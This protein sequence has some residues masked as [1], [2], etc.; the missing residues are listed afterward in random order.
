MKCP[1]SE[2]NLARARPADPF[3]EDAHPRLPFRHLPDDRDRAGR[4]QVVGARLV[5]VVLLQDQQDHAIP[6]ERT[7]DRLDRHA[8]A[9]AQRR[10]RHR[11]DHGA[12]QR[13]DGKF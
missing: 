12:A 11:E 8:T 3:D 2:R 5:T 13:H 4:V 10:H 1:R 6:G 9:D 7:V